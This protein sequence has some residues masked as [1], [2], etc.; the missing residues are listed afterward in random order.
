MGGAGPDG[1]WTAPVE[2]RGP[3]RP[4]PVDQEAAA[5]AELLEDELLEDEDDDPLAAAA[6]LLPLSEEVPEPSEDELE[7]APTEF[8]PE[9]FASVE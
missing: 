3:V 7:E 8:A 9:D 5:C 4:A 6:V 1:G 2:G